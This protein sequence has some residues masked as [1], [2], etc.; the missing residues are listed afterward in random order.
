MPGPGLVLVD[1]NVILDIRTEDPAWCEWSAGALA[2]AAERHELAINPIVYAEVSIDADRIEDLD[3]ELPER[4]YR[5]LPL[6]YEAGFLAG[7]VFVRYRRA[8][9]ERRSPLP[10]FYIGAHAA[11]SGLILLTRD[12]SRY[13]SYFPTVQLISPDV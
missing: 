6:P 1:A 5:R 4:D 2:E 12:A 7:K 11:V 9:G 13:R 8:G 10:D 3:D